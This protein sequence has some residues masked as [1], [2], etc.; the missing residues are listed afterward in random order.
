MS[1]DAITGGGGGGVGSGRKRGIRS[2]MM[3]NESRAKFLFP[4]F[5]FIYTRDFAE[6]LLTFHVIIRFDPGKGNVLEL[7]VA[8]EK[9]S[10][11]VVMEHFR[12]LST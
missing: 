1:C 12:S 6:A 8:C 7:L 5:I 4:F 3:D 11:F 10:Y 9:V 2:M